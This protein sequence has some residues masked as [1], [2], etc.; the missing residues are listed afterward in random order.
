MDSI[1]LCQ[2]PLVTDIKLPS[3]ETLMKSGRVPTVSLHLLVKNGASCVGRLLDNVGPYLREVVAVVNDTTDRTIEILQQKCEVH[4][5]ELLVIEATAE[6]HP[7]FYIL[8][9]PETYQ[10][11]SP[12]ADECYEGPFTGKPLLA[13]WAALRN[14]GW[15]KCRCE[16]RLFLD[17]DDFVEDPRSIPGLC[18]ALEERGVDLATSRYQFGTTAGGRSRA[19]AFRERLAANKPEIRWV[20]L[21]HEVLKGQ[22]RTAHIEGSLLVVDRRDS[23]GEGLRPSGRCFKVLY[24]EARWALSE[25]REVSA[26]TWLYLA[27]ESKEEVP[28]LALLALTQYM[29]ISTWKEERAW[30]WVMR[31]EIAE[32]RGEMK[33]AVEAYQQSFIEHPGTKAAFRACKAYFAMRHWLDCLN[34]YRLG[35]ANKTTLQV[36]ESGEVF[37]DAC[38]ILVAASYGKLGRVNEALGWCKEAL[39]CFPDNKA[40]LIMKAEFEKAVA[41]GVP[42][43]G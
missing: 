3:H 24:H 41:K 27:M 7:W 42:D 20:G 38:K 18:L 36:I 9:V 15:D 12:L 17:A 34:M 26:R 1:S 39:A 16:W 6:T 8:D 4:N 32:A 21:V 43:L 23:T 37:E 30:A 40:L 35:V 5:L 29:A 22:E 31:G 13:D 19:D 14:L 25:G 11:G 28:E 10:E 33:T 2:N